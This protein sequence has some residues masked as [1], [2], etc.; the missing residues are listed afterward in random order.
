MVH[1]RMLPC[2][3][4]HS[5]NRAVSHGAGGSTARHRP[6]SG[7]GLQYIFR[8]YGKRREGGGDCGGADGGGGRRYDG[9]LPP[10]EATMGKGTPN[11]EHGKGGKGDNV[12]DGL[13]PGD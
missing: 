5:D 9:A 2:P 6:T 13:P 10:E 12:S 4:R 11:V 3:Q 8:G 7:G 1:H